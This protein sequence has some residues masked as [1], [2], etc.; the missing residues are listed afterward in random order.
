MAPVYV[1]NPFYVLALSPVKEGE[2]SETD[3]YWCKEAVR[4]GLDNNIHII[5]IGADGDSKFRKF[6][7]DKYTKGNE[8]N[9]G[10]TLD[11]EGFDFSS[12]TKQFG[13]L[14]STTVM[15]PDWKHLIKKW[16]NQL[17]NTKKLLLMGK[18]VPQIE[19]L[20]TIYDTYKLESGLWKS[21]IFVR[22]KQ[23]VDAA[24][25]ILN[26]AVC[27]CLKKSNE[28]LTKGLR[29][30]LSVG[31]SLL[32]CFTDKSL[33]P[34][35]RANLAWKPVIFLR[36]WKT[37]LLHEK[38]DPKTHFVSD[39]TYT[40]AILA[41]HSVILNMLVFAKYFPDVPFCPWLFGSDS[42][43][44][45]FSYLRGFTKGKNNFNFLEMLDITARVIKL[46]E[47]KYRNKHRDTYENTAWPHNLESEVIEGMKEAEREIVKTMDEMEMIPG[48]RAADVIY[49]NQRTGE[50]TILNSPTKAYVSEK[51]AFPDE[52]YVTP[53]E[54]LFDLD[55]NILL[56]SLEQENSNRFEL[57]GIIAQTSSEKDPENELDEGDPENCHLFKRGIC[58]FQE[59]GFVEPKTVHWIGC[60]FPDCLKWW[61]EICL[62]IKFKAEEERNRY[63]FVCPNHDC[64]MAD[65]YPDQ[66]K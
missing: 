60:E 66:Q 10:L 25:R 2:T 34:K 28:A 56:N 14:L 47:L 32:R 36:L 45:L 5:G 40:D 49:K 62:G 46:L 57:A 38:Y 59:Q 31:S 3:A 12:E 61:H 4:M 26:P 8:Q 27:Q 39:Q 44:V 19:N 13:T 54:E 1:S 53:F 7:L 51:T 9:N 18:S 63:S 30:Y 64:D 15:Q 16:R 29:V 50:L 20:M 43:E 35:E 17:L 21:D 37:W 22:D 6:F 42:C 65:I 23:N 58:K 33:L 41:G 11:Y 52:T 55:N 24:K 48:L